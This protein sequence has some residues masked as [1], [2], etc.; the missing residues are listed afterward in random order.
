MVTGIL[1]I[2][3]HDAYSLIDPGS[4]LS[5]VTPYFALD[6]GMKPEPLLEPFVVDTPMGVPVIASRVYKNCVVVIMGR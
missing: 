6:M 3:S 4:N 5:Y 2:C 1:T